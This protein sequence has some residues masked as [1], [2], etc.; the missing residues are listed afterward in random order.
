MQGVGPTTAIEML[1]LY[2]TDMLRQYL[3][4]R[5]VAAIQKCKGVGKKSAERLVLN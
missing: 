4:Q 5:D 2:D 1:S 3:A